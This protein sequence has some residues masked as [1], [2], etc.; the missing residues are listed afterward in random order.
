MGVPLEAQVEKIRAMA[1]VQG[2]MMVD[3]I[4]DAGE[5]AK[6]LN[7]PEWRVGRRFLTQ[8]LSTRLSLPNWIG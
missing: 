1:V 6:D 7:R 2:G 3:I 5:S 4:I 8:A